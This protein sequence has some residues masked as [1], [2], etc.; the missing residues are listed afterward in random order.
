MDRGMWPTGTCSGSSCTFIS[1]YFTNL[2]PR[3]W[4]GQQA[5]EQE[6]GGV[7]WT[8]R[9]D[10]K[11]G[12]TTGACRRGRVASTRGCQCTFHAQ[13]APTRQSCQQL[14]PPA[15]AAGRCSCCSCS[16]SRG[17]PSA[18]GSSWRSPAPPQGQH[19]R[20]DAR[21]S[22][23]IVRLDFGGG[24]PGALKPSRLVPTIKSLASKLTKHAKPASQARCQSA[25][26][27]VS[28]PSQPQT[29]TFW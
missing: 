4:R 1:W 6:E 22:L 24:G 10:R 5:D 17:T 15:C 19:A 26:P 21:A 25:Q 12:G 16:F 14:A 3:V 29:R 27:V 28:H 7:A 8:W 13:R 11:D 9:G 23:R 18:A 2:E 20:K